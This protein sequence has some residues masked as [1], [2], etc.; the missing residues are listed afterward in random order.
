LRL[1]AASCPE[2][3]AVREASG[4]T[5][6]LQVLQFR[7][8]W[9]SLEIVEILLG[10]RACGNG[11]LP[12]WAS[13]FPLHTQHETSTADRYLN[14]AMV[15]TADTGQLPLHIA[16]EG[17]PADYSLIQTLQES[18]PGAIYVP[19]ARGRTPLH[20][21][22]HSYRRIPADAKVLEL[23]FSERVAQIVYEGGQLPLDLLIESA[24]GLPSHQPRAAS[25]HNGEDGG[26]GS[27]TTTCSINQYINAPNK[28]LTRK[29]MRTI[30]R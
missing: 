29:P 7:D 14:P 6:L 16:A 25:M 21:A 1:F 12:P 17:M 8:A 15:P 26:G 24:R 9:P 28:K 11:A 13:D 22:L 10:K 20:L 3:L 30:P 18:Y 19:D 2:A 23:L 5:P 4:L 27:T